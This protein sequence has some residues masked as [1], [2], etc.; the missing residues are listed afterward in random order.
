MTSLPLRR[1]PD[2]SHPILASDSSWSAP[3]FTGVPCPTPETEE[4]MEPEQEHTAS[5]DDCWLWPVISLFQAQMPALVPETDPP[6][7]IRSVPDPNQL[8]Q[9][10]VIKSADRDACFQLFSHLPAKSRITVER[11]ALVCARTGKHPTETSGSGA[12]G[13]GG[14][15]QSHVVLL[16]RTTRQLAVISS[17]LPCGQGVST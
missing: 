7:P 12:S 9:R 3:E 16:L 10:A 17:G 2:L 14:G 13:E 4:R 6:P 5:T 8:L 1:T 15:G 11:G